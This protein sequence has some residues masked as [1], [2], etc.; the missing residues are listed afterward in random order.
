M[1]VAPVMSSCRRS[2][3]KPVIALDILCSA[4]IHAAR[5]VCRNYAK[6]LGCADRDRRRRNRWL[7]RCRSKSDL[8]DVGGCEHHHAAAG[9]G[10]CA[11]SDAHAA[12]ADAAVTN[13]TVTNT[14]SADAG[15]TDAGA[16]SAAHADAAASADT[17]AAHTAAG[18]EVHCCRDAG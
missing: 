16:T 13:T 1:W 2:A 4:I 17:A 10:A 12:S 9:T 14:E 3:G 5:L 8:A 7:Q 15:T 6:G 11:G 18:A